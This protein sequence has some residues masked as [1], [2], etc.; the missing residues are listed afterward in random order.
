[1]CTRTGEDLSYS[2]EIVFKAEL[3]VHSEYFDQREKY[4]DLNLKLLVDDF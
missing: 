3:K 4:L 2:D 1:V